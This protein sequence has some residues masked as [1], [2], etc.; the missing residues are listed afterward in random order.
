MEKIEDYDGETVI[1]K[2][3][4]MNRPEKMIDKEGRKTVFHYNEMGNL[5]EEITPSGAITQFFYDGNNRLERVEV[6]KSE[7]EEACKVTSY[8]YD[9]VGNLVRQEKGD[10]NKIAEEITWEYDPLNRVQSVT[11]PLGGKKN[12]KYNQEGLLKAIIDEEGN[13]R[14]FVYNKAGELVEETDIYGNITQYTYNALGQIEKR[15][16]GGGR[17][18]IHSYIKGGRRIKTKYPEG[19]E[20]SYE[21]DTLG[22]IKTKS[23]G[24]YWR[25]DYEYDSLGRLKKEIGSQ[26]EERTYI[27]NLS[28]KVICKG[29]SNGNTTYY[30]YTR[31]GDLAAIIDPMGSR[32][33]YEYDQGERIEWIRQYGKE[34]E[35]MRFTRYKRNSLG[36][37]EGIQ[38][39]L[40]REEKF[41]YDSLGRIIEKWNQEGERIRYTYSPGGKIEK[42]IY[43]EG[44]HTEMEYT[45]LGQL[46]VLRDW[47]GETRIFRDKRGRIEK[48]M[49]HKGREIHYEWGNWGERKK[50]RYSNGK[51]VFFEYDQALRLIKLRKDEEGKKGFEISYEYDKEGRLVKKQMPGGIQTEWTY[52]AQGYPKE[53]IQKD[54]RGMID[55]YCYQYD[56]TGRKILLEKER[57]G[58]PK[59]RGTYEY[60]YDAL[61]RLVEV[62][63][64]GKLLCKYTY[65]S[66]GNRIE[67]EKMGRRT[68]YGYNAL[69][70]LIW[71]ESSPEYERVNY[72]YDARGNL[73]GEYKGDRQ[74]HSY[75]YNMLNNLEKAFD[76]EG[77]E[78]TY[79]YN[80]LGQRVGRNEEEYVLDLT[81]PYYN[82]LERIKKEK[83]QS[84]YWDRGL[85]AFETE[86]MGG[87]QYILTDE[88]G[89]PIRIL[90]ENGKEY[91]YGYDEYGMDLYE[92]KEKGY[93]RQGEG[94]L[95]GYTGYRYDDI[96]GTYFAQAREYQPEIG[97]F[98]S[99]D[100]IRGNAENPMT[101]NPYGYCGNDPVNWVDLDGNAA[102]YYLNNMDGARILD[103]LLY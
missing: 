27:Y 79:Y 33:E 15:I 80:G 71:E 10:G 43:G 90:Y 44:M 66:F 56:S 25:Q 102:V 64:E 12:Y 93:E 18:T 98:I 46:A 74:I 92:E 40:G 4:C 96:S 7:G 6:K 100:A 63:R 65:D 38:D 52:N 48:V 24:Q 30:E 88:M 11:N 101:L 59:E 99:Q 34:G 1:L 70:Q 82:L 55:R 103:I 84:Y 19:L 2:Y 69:N 94:Q 91:A 28:G 87:P 42:I 32:T 62:K 49:D 83:S 89:S 75:S 31:G 73:I 35:E 78:A 20:V 61:Q 37:I 29:D 3:D 9:P 14:T 68:V 21:Y 72:T 39:A 47:L 76:K 86:E 95:F 16:D 50:I 13:K 54:G 17:I 5:A 26:G 22:R 67:R 51:E 77:R 23:A 85:A 45:A 53:L 8:F 97:R 36:Q 58:L 41:V 60:I 57:K 81:K